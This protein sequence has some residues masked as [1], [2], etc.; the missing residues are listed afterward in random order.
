MI[1]QLR[2]ENRERFENIIPVLGPFHTQVAF[3]TAI[4]KRFEG[5]GLSELIV[6]ADIVAEKSVDKALKGKHFRRAVRALQLVYEAL[7]RCIIRNG[8]TA[9]IKLSA[10]LQASLQKLRETN[11]Y[12]DDEMKWACEELKRSEEFGSFIAK[13]YNLVHDTPMGQY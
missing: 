13:A 12:S 6:S 4:S 2:N 5:S 11:L 9:G 1:V 3:I 8:V 7:Q 10:N